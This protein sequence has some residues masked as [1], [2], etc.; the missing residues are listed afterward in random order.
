MVFTSP[1]SPRRSPLRVNEPAPYRFDG[2]PAAREFSADILAAARGDGHALAT[3]N[4]FLRQAFS[5][6]TSDLPGVAPTAA[7]A[8]YAPFTATAT[9]LWAAIARPAPFTGPAPFLAPYTQSVGGAID[10]AAGN[11]V[12]P[13]GGTL[14][15][16]GNT[17]TPSLVTG[18]FHLNREVFDQRE[19]NPYMSAAIWAEVERAYAA[20]LESRAAAA[21]AALSGTTN[22]ALS[23]TG[24]TLVT[25]LRNGLGVTIYRRAGALSN[26]LYTALVTANDSQG[27]PLLA[28]APIDQGQADGVLIGN[29]EFRF[30]DALTSTVS[31][32]VNPDYTRGWATPPREIVMT[33]KA[34]PVSQVIL[35]VVG[36]AA[37]QPGHPAGVVKLTY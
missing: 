19:G 8:P 25:A 20:A 23:G 12:E 1:S 30:S 14:A 22:I 11:G 6:G 29:R 27:R 9:P 15:V 3:V 31:W 4:T 33:S 10:G 13:T 35:G 17:L 24:S 7:L 26:T 2:R 34:A 28:P 5:I 21:L 32:V 36:Y 16:G 37:I 18:S